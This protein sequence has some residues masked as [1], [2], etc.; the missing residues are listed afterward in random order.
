VFLLWRSERMVFMTFSAH[1]AS[2]GS[3]LFEALLERKRPGFL[4]CAANTRDHKMDT[5][6][7][8][9]SFVQTSKR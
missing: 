7:I 3:D 9:L 8:F 4:Q 1:H 5:D 6:L 2:L